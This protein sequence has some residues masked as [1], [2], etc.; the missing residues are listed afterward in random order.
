[1]SLVIDLAGR[2]IHGTIFF[3]QW[4]HADPGRTVCFQNDFLDDM[5]RYRDA[6]PTYPIVV[7]DELATVHRIE[8][9]GP[10]DEA[11]IACAPADLPPGYH[12]GAG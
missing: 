10:G 3:P 7:V 2:R 11:V 8:D 12:G 1:M 6:G 4:V 9:R 5:R